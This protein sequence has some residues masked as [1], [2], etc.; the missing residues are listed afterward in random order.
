MSD[1]KNMYRTIT[2][3]AFPDEMKIT[4]GNTELKYKKRTWTLGDET[5][6]LRYGENPDQP[7]ALYEL[8]AGEL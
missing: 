2:A 6:G 4:L 5:R 7:A 1:L 8:E 3:D